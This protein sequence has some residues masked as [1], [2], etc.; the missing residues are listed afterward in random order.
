MNFLNKI[1]SL[2]EKKRKLI[3]WVTVIVIALILLVIWI[4]F[5]KQR[6]E[7]FNMEEFKEGLE[8]PS[9]E[10]PELPSFEE[11]MENLMNTNEENQ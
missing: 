4:K 8:L 11:S 1:R 6:I 7:S 2:P 3:L 9:L 5:S 10:G